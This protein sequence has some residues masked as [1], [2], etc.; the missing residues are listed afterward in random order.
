MYNIENIEIIK[1]FLVLCN[2][3]LSSQQNDTNKLIEIFKQFI[4]NEK[5]KNICNLSK[6]SNDINLLFKKFISKYNYEEILDLSNNELN[7][8]IPNEI[9]NIRQFL[10]FNKTKDILKIID[11]SGNYFKGN[12]KLLD[13]LALKYN[14]YINITNDK[15]FGIYEY[16]ENNKGKE[17][18]KKII[19]IEEKEIFQIK[20]I[21]NKEIISLHILYYSLLNKYK[22]KDIFYEFGLKNDDNFL[23]FMLTLLFTFSYPYDFIKIL[24]NYLIIEKKIEHKLKEKILNFDINNFGY[25]YDIQNINENNKKVI[26]YDIHNSINHNFLNSFKYPFTKFSQNSDNY[27]IE[28]NNT[29]N[30]MRLRSSFIYS[31]FYNYKIHKNKFFI[32]QY[33]EYK[34]KIFKLQLDQYCESIKNGKYNN[35][36]EENL[37]GEYINE[38]LNIIIDEIRY[39]ESKAKNLLIFIFNNCILPPLSNGMVNLDKNHIIYKNLIEQLKLDKKGLETL[40]RNKFENLIDFI[41]KPL[42]DEPDSIESFNQKLIYCKSRISFM[43]FLTLKFP[44]FN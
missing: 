24:K 3:S 21:L 11:L 42:N 41:L 10:D 8:N 28:I 18:F 26:P 44:N 7:I 12:I 29:L 25:K 27:L 20:E 22:K 9:E 35:I 33:N 13:D 15:S 5:A 36:I 14:I 39:N 23:N 40:E 31:Y 37:F 6:V 32:D 17:N 1:E 43:L 30:N 16:N 2:P 34:K 19:W 4:G 38:K